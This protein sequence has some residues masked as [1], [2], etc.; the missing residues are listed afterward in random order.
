VTEGLYLIE[1]GEHKFNRYRLWWAEKSNG[2]TTDI[3]LAGRYSEA[4]AKSI[5]DGLS[6]D[7]GERMWQVVQ[8]LSGEAG[9]IQTWRPD[10]HS[11][12][13]RVI[14]AVLGKRFRRRRR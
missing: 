10:P 2:Y 7:R 12:P 14:R 9:P 6:P 8:V 1:C 4:E 3:D 5:C 13:N 11:K